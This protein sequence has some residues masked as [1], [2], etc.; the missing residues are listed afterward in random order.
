M[1]L[2]SQLARLLTLFFY[3]V[4]LISLNIEEVIMYSRR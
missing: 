4:E 3:F 2:Y 1:Y